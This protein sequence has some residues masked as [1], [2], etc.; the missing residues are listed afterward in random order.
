MKPPAKPPTLIR[1]DMTNPTKEQPTQEELREATEQARELL[2][3]YQQK[4][5]GYDIPY[6]RIEAVALAL[7]TKNLE[8]EK[9]RVEGALRMY[10]ELVLNRK[11]ELQ[12]IAQSVLDKLK[13]E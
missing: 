8:I 6:H 13:G 9:A 5:R 3:W 1:S 12:K 4:T 2:G 11:D 10:D 7:H